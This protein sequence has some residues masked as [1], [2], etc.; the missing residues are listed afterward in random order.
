MHF[1]N[2]NNNHLN[3]KQNIE[4]F[5]RLLHASPNAPSVDVFVNNLPLVKDFEYTEFTD[6]VKLLPGKYNVKVVKSSNSS[7]VLYDTILDVPANKIFTIAAIGNFP[8]DFELYPIVED[9]TESYDDTNV[10]LR[11]VNLIP[12]S[13]N[14]DVTFD[15]NELLFSDVMYKEVENYKELPPKKY[16]FDIKLQNTDVTILYIPNANL[17]KN[18]FY[19]IYLVGLLGGTPGLQG[20]IPL[21]G[22]TYLKDF[23]DMYI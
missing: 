9:F 18:K 10:Q 6:Y 12:E 2:N 4:S 5:L 15:G 8:D 19:T 11:V 20:L 3:D 17:H 23:S 21:D 1:R 22:L 16:N 7:D 14:V 13:P